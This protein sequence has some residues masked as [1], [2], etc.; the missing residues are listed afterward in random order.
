M[1]K[2]AFLVNGDERS[3]AAERANAF[4]SRLR[5]RYDIRVAYR[6]P[7]KFGSMLRLFAFLV[8]TKPQITYVVDMSY[9][10]VVA[11]VMYKFTTRACLIIDTG[12]AICELGRSMG[13]SRMGLWFTRMLEMISFRGADRIVVRGTLHQMLLEQRGIH[14]E[15]IQDG[16]DTSQFKPMDVSG[17][18]KEHGL[19]GI[20]T[21]GT[22]GSV[23]WNEALGMCYGSEVAEVVHLLKD[24]PVKGVIIGDGPGLSRLKGLCREYGVEDRV[25]FL[26]RVAYDELP[27]FLN[28]ID[29]CISTQTNDVVGQVRT[30]GKLPLY[31]ATGRYVLATRVGEASLCLPEEM[32]VDY[33]GKRDSFYVRRLAERVRRL[34][35]GRGALARG[36]ENIG[37]ARTRFDYS[38]LADRLANLL[39]STIHH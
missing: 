26:G 24:A 13:R 27:R 21:I 22:V 9:S 4:A 14:A 8:R 5:N 7:R 23:V 25:S 6:S 33:Y 32:L 36:S 12:D 29:V 31:M 10:G 1:T 17:L 28:L 39:D 30:T 35:E 34:M 15:L 2:V 38:V 11:A 16:V 18:R 3:A 37:V 19:E 20:L